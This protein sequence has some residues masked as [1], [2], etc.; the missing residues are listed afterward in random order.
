MQRKETFVKLILVHVYAAK[1]DADEQ[2]KED[3]YGK[4]QEEDEQIYIWK[5]EK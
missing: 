5:N 3:F 2:T 1:N 4:L